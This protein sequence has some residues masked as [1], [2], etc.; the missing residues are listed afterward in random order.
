MLIS[1]LL[2]R[3]GADVAT[4]PPTAPVSAVLAGL[5]EHGVGALVVSAAQGQVDGIV[6]ERDIVRALHRLGPGVLNEPVSIIMS[7]TVQFCAP[8]D[9]VDSLAA[10]MTEL[11][12][13]HVPVLADGVLAG[14]VSIGDVVKSRIGELEQD[15][16][17]LE[18]YIS[19]R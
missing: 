7:T 15:R 9:T 2:S 19:A 8:T 13:R 18:H 17:A 3:K 16:R 12:V 6:S 4:V 5:A 14:I 10:T 1:E 11:R